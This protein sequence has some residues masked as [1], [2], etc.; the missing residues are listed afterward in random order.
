MRNSGSFFCTGGEFPFCE[1]ADFFHVLG[2]F[3]ADSNA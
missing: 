2:K 3:L 1:T